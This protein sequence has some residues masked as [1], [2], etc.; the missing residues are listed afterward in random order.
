MEA[1]AAEVGRPEAVVGPVPEPDLEERGLGH[2]RPAGR[3][4]A[5]DV[6]GDDGIEAG[7]RDRCRCRI[8]LPAAFGCDLAGELPRPR[9]PALTAR[10]GRPPL[11]GRRLPEQALERRVDDPARF[12]C[13]GIRVDRLRPQLPADEPAVGA[14]DELLEG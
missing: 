10:L 7:E 8:D 4:V 12:E 14:A 6:A 9:D 2:H 11:G 13:I 3:G 1:E 5:T